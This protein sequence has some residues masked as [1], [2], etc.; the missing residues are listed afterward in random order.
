AFV[1]IVAM[2]LLPASLARAQELMFSSAIAETCL[3]DPGVTDR[4]DFT[5]CI[6]IAAEA[7]MEATEGGWS[8]IGMNACMAAERVYWDD[9][10]NAMYRTLLKSDAAEDAEAVRI[11]LTVPARAPALRDMQR[12]WI[13]YRDERCEYVGTQWAGGTGASSATINCLMVQTGE[14]AIYLMRTLWDY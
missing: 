5:S 14:Q 6:G 3:A 13:T 2:A 7:C 10:L 4:G 12:A 9:K 8:T 11:G 1:L